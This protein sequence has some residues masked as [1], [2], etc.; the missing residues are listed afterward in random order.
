MTANIQDTINYLSKN[1]EAYKFR[2][3]S[4]IINEKY[5]SLKEI[6]N[7][8]KTHINDI[9]NTYNKI[10]CN[11]QELIEIKFFIA[12]KIASILFNDT[13]VEFT[14]NKNELDTNSFSIDI[15]RRYYES[16]YP[17]EYY[18]VGINTEENTC[19]ISIVLAKNYEI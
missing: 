17:I 10:E 3:L 7:E 8:A 13:D 4:I 12:N 11:T 16:E 15:P 2:V 19:E 9:C 14:V 5:Y 18:K 1:T 6:H